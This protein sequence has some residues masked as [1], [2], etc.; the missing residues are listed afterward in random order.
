M[1]RPKPWM[2]AE[3]ALLVKLCK[4]ARPI[5]R[6]LDLFPGRTLSGIYRHMQEFGLRKKRMQ[7]RDPYRAGQIEE[8]LA[9]RE[10]CAYEIA[11]EWGVTLPTVRPLLNRLRAEKKIYIAERVRLGP[12]VRTYRWALG[13]KPDAP[14]L[15]ASKSSAVSKPKLV[16]VKPVTVV[17]VRRDPLTEAL[18]GRAA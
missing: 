5:S 17:H 12:T 2:Q 8:M 1:S 11:A 16:E 10:M 18:F 9:K 15:H 3:H 13:D 4:E 7:G 6:N 14:M